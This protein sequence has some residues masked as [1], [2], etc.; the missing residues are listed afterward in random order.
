LDFDEEKVEKPKVDD[1][2]LHT[3]NLGEIVVENKQ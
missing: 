3:E 1:V 2:E